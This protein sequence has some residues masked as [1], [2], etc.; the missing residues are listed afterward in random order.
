MAQVRVYHS[1]KSR[2]YSYSTEKF[3]LI[4]FISSYSLESSVTFPFSNKKTFL[5]TINKLFCITLPAFMYVCIYLHFVA[6]RTKYK[7]FHIL[8][9]VSRRIWILLYSVLDI[10]IHI[11]QFN[12]ITTYLTIKLFDS[13]LLWCN[14][15]YSACEYKKKIK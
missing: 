14:S 5:Y 13:F 15:M 8:F 2:I 11:W 1:C 10:D 12:K 4:L 9:M 7:L 3:N 6:F